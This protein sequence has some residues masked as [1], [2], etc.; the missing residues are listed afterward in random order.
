MKKTLITLTASAIIASA[1]VPEAEASSGTYKVEQGDS[2][3]FIAQKHALTIEKL[4]SL[5]NLKSNLIY[6]DQV[7]T[8]PTTSSIST[9]PQKKK[10]PTITK[11]NSASPLQFSTYTVKAGDS[12]SK[13]AAQHN[14]SLQDLMSWN[15]L[16]TTLIFPG[17]VFQV[18]KKE[19]SIPAPASVE[20]PQ[21]VAQT[22]TLYKV[23]AGDYLGKIAKNH[24]VSVLEL[25]QWNNLSS[26][27]IRVGQALQVKETPVSTK[28]PQTKTAAETLDYNVDMLINEGKK[29]LGLAYVWGG[30]SPSG[31]D[32]SGFVHYLYNKAGKSMPRYTSDGYF[33]RSYYVNKPVPG[34]L[35]FFSGTY[36]P[37]ISHLGIYIGDN[38]FMHAE[39]GGVKIT[40]LDN[41]YWKKHFDSIKRLY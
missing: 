41:T 17:E 14:I 32:C 35:V 37:G 20:P 10:T 30:A 13:I 18:S 39:S 25:K 29:Y 24:G 33:N 22:A 8:I 5:N 36:R 38:K 9:T 1:Y 40:S 31:F 16:T 11:E 15:K 26:D 23:K 34:D 2:L 3:W 21:T 6:P 4:K 27:L 7:L 19:T 12:L 28:I